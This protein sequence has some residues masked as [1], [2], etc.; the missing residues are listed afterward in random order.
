MFFEVYLLVEI[1][2]AIM[3]GTVIKEVTRCSLMA[4][5]AKRASNFG[6]ITW[7]PPAINTARADEIPPM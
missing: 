4:S 3:V 2:S 6:S 5:L 7:Q 1:K